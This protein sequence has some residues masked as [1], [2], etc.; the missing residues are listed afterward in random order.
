MSDS[1]SYTS[2][3]S[4]ES[5]N[6]ALEGYQVKRQIG[7]GAMGVVF[8]AEQ[9][10]LR[11]QVAIKVLPTSMA[12]R[13][14]TVRRF[15]REASA[16]GRLSHENI[17][18]VYE[19]GSIDNLHFFSMKYVEGP[20]LDRV[21]KA[22]PLA[23]GD[24]ISIG[25]D[26]A[27]ALSH[28]HSH[29]VMHRDIKPGNLLRDRDRV[30]LTDF[31]L[32]RP[33]DSEETGT[34]TES[35]DLVGTPLYMAPEQITADVAKI[36]G[37]SDIWAL[38]VT[39]YE[40]L[41][42]RPPFPGANAQ[43][44][45]NAILHKD[46]ALLHKM[47]DDVPRDLEAVILKCLE[48][49]LGRR[50]SGAAALLEDLEAVRDGRPVSASAPRFYDPPLRWIRRHPFEA[51]VVASAL[52]VALLLGLAVHQRSNELDKT[53][54]QRDL[55][56]FAQLEAETLRDE[57]IEA[58]TAAHVSFEL[59]QARLDW[60]RARD[61]GDELGQTEAVGRVSDLIRSLYSNQ[62]TSLHIN[63]I[64]ECFGV[65]AEMASNFDADQYETI[66][67]AYLAGLGEYDQALALHRDRSR[68]TP[69]SS[70]PLLD[71]AMLMRRRATGADEDMDPFQRTGFLT[72][73]LAMTERATQLAIES[74]DA[75]LLTTVLIEAARCR[76]ELGRSGSAADGRNDLE[77]AIAILLRAIEQDA[78]RVEAFVLLET[79]ERKLEARQ[80]REAA[81]APQ[82]LLPLPTFLADVG[83]A[84]GLDIEELMETAPTLDRADLES[85]GRGLQTIFTGLRNLMQSAG[86]VEEQ[87]TP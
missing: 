82:A 64:A 37:R 61:A 22:G 68:K 6:D 55:A 50:Y 27:R 36:D 70:R 71:A 74:G 5:L 46:P 23:I 14:R 28:A 30:V 21:L 66:Y 24:V 56:Q 40:L 39:L 72:Q 62:D 67:A 65:L 38:G 16:M 43:S 41:T 32:A 19:V 11:R 1:S 58:R 29:G 45:L 20:P 3:A 10:R 35:G 80:R 31:G 12:L 4:V 53:E 57:A 2:L 51:S 9:Q 7:H 69:E 18:A 63:E 87:E 15:L 42:Q 13:T 81:G 49:D 73:A 78:T 8:E 33:L 75:Q 44:I 77:Q 79:A 52:G 86:T 84:P 47:R 26:V 83:D 48:K 54:T 25:I 76:I 34:M 85:A 59:S 17:V 60:A